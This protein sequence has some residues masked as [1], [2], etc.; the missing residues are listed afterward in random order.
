MHDP[1][2]DKGAGPLIISLLETIGIGVRREV[3]VTINLVSKIHA[4]GDL[5]GMLGQAIRRI[6]TLKK[7]VSETAGEPIRIGGGGIQMIL[8]S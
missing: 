2:T 4:T 3:D 5:I 7:R 8:V 1:L 6:H